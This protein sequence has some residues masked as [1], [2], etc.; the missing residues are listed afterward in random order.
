[1]SGD[2]LS[3]IASLIDVT[4]GAIMDGYNWFSNERAYKAAREDSAWSKKLALWNAYQQ[5]REF[6]YAKDIQ[7]QIFEREDNAVQRRVA[8]LEK[9]GLSNTL[10]AGSGAGA[11]SVVSTHLSN[12]GNP[13]S[14]V[15]KPSLTF[16]NSLLD[17]LKGVEEIKGIKEQINVAKEQ[18]NRIKAETDSIN[19]E[20]DMK[21]YDFERVKQGYGMNKSHGTALDVYYALNNWLQDNAVE[22]IANGV[23]KTSEALKKG[24]YTYVQTVDKGLKK[25]KSALQSFRDHFPK[26][27]IEDGALVIEEPRKKWF[28]NRK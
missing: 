1:M 22:P 26:V 16:Q 6:D 27:Y 10:A 19:L 7:N 8:D 23:D 28:N 11:G 24:Y 3:G 21:K 9:S 5:Q 20:N 12:V 14:N 17:V 2:M 25:G 18:K 15:Q 4:N 13:T